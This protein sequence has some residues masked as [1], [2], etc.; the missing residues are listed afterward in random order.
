MVVLHQSKV[1]DEFCLNCEKAAADITDVN[2]PGNTAKLRK[3]P[4][5]DEIEDTVFALRPTTC[6][7]I[8]A[9]V[10]DNSDKLRQFFRRRLQ[11]RGDDAGDFTASVAKC[12]VPCRPFTLIDVVMN[13]AKPGIGGANLIEDAARRVG[14]AIVD[15]NAL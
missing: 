2:L 5:G 6:T 7:D 13:R 10:N 15:Q 11:V 9:L 1:F 8:E 3:D 12:R 14:A 4:C